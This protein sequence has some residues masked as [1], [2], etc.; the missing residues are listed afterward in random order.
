MIGPVAFRGQTQQGRS[1]MGLNLGKTT[2]GRQF[3]GGGAIHR[4]LVKD[5]P[6]DLPLWTLPLWTDLADRLQGFPRELVENVMNL[7]REWGEAES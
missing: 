7:W 3:G 2:M 5:L 4:P 6:I 1:G